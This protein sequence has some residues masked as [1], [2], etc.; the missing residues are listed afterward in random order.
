[1]FIFL[2]FAAAIVLEVL[3]TYVSIIGLADSFAGDKI[4]LLFAASLDFA[5]IVLVTGLYRYWDSVH[6]LL[7]AYLLPAVAVLMLVTAYGEAGYLQQAFD[8][9]MAPSSKDVIVLQESEAERSRLLARQ[10]Q[11]DDQIAAIDPKQVRQRIRE[12]K[13]LAPERERI[14]RRVT[15]LNAL[16]LET[17][18]KVTDGQAHIGPIYSLA[19]AFNIEPATSAKIIILMMV[20]VFDPLAI[21]LILLGNHALARRVK[22]EAPVVPDWPKDYGDDGFFDDIAHLP[23]DDPIEEQPE[24]TEPDPYITTPEEVMQILEHDIDM[25]AIHAEPDDVHGEVN[26]DWYPASALDDVTLSDD[27]LLARGKHGGAEHLHNLYKTGA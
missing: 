16:A 15:E 1:M 18:Q 2:I 17:K 11:I 4:I 24:P 20:V 25:D 12:T 13:L 10:K 19:S 26:M 14:E 9:A 6:V 21:A 27:A 8:K 3:G 7:K 22:P 5:K 23:E